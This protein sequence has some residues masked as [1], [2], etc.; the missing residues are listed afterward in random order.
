[1][2][3][4][5]PALLARYFEA[6]NGRDVEAMLASFAADPV[7][8]DEHREHRGA[9]AVREWIVDV[10]KKYEPQVEVVETM[11]DGSNVTVDVSVSGNFPGSPLQLRYAFVLVEQRI[12]RLE[13][14]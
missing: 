13:I 9:A 4:R 12:A 2:T 1:L 6:Q 10:T 8:C 11:V 5:L 3:T 14:S 7:V